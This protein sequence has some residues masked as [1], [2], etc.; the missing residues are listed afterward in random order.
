MEWLST[1][2]VIKAAGFTSYALLLISVSLG[3]FSYGKHLSQ[4]F[5][6][7]CLTLHQMTGWLGLLFGM[8]HGVVLTIDSYITFSWKA[9]W[10]PMTAEY[11]PIASGLGTI[12]FYLILF[13]L[14]TSDWMKKF[15]KKI[16]RYVH[17]LAYPAFALSLLHGL[18]AGSDSQSLW[19]I[20]FYQGSAVVFF[21]IF[22]VRMY[23]HWKSNKKMHYNN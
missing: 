23:M 18:F 15:G 7:I 8:L 6:S 21:A 9:V 16:W 14:I 19:A 4:Q 17:F 3:A 1:W 22:F 5:R 11:R 20:R 13:I 10:I 12:A 2:S